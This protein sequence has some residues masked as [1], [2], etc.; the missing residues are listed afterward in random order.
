MPKTDQKDFHSW[1]WFAGLSCCVLTIWFA[2]GTLLP[3][4]IMKVNHHL[5]GTVQETRIDEKSIAS[6]SRNDVGDAPLSDSTVMP[7]R[8]S[9]DSLGQLGDQF[10]STSAL[11]TGLAL[12][13]AIVTLMRQSHDARQSAKESKIEQM[14]QS[15][16][17]NTLVQQTKAVIESNKLAK[18]Q[19]EVLINQ[20]QLS[21]KVAFIEEFRFFRDSIAGARDRIIVNRGGDVIGSV[22]AVQVLAQLVGKHLASSTRVDYIG[23]PMPKGTASDRHWRAN[24]L[25]DSTTALHNV[26]SR[27][28]DILKGIEGTKILP[29]VRL[30][31]ARA[32]ALGR[33]GQSSEIINEYRN[34]FVAET[35]I[36]DR[37]LLFVACVGTLCLSD[38]A[39]DLQNRAFE[40][41]ILWSTGVF[42]DLHYHETLKN[43]IQMA[44]ERARCLVLKSPS[45]FS[46][47]QLRMQWDNDFMK[48]W[49]LTHSGI[50][51]EVKT[52]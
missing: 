34:V 8:T 16:Q 1:K 10:G 17:L 20:Q 48:R 26:Q 23:E 25:A 38:E 40:Y 28:F 39:D 41:E 43:I 19:L 32:F 7:K 29:F 4:V 45:T 3:S 35:G 52:S 27:S 44:N 11:F 30:I 14:H 9:Q 50:E 15:E 5:Y 13:G 21:N 49:R 6:Q 47:M 46:P 33:R 22:L 2:C 37:L 12:A 51:S 18:A 31:T 24:W 36:E 42:D